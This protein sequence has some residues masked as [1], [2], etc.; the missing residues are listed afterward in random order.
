MLSYSQIRLKEFCTIRNISFFI[1]SSYRWNDNLKLSVSSFTE[2]NEQAMFN[3]ASGAEAGCGWWAGPRVD[4]FVPRLL[5]LIINLIE[6]I[7]SSEILCLLLKFIMLLF[8]KVEK[9][10]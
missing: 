1:L 8:Y 7:F 9:N 2:H 3:S 4:Q 10:Y 5:L 6:C